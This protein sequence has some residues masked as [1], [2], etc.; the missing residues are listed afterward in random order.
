[1]ARGGH[2]FLLIKFVFKLAI[3]IKSHL[4][5]ISTKFYHEVASRRVIMPCNKIAKLLMV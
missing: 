2:V 3:F 1:M 5:T 4:G